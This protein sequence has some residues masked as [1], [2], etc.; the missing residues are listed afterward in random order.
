MNYDIIVFLILLW[1]G[2]VKEVYIFVPYPVLQ[3]RGTE[4]MCKAILISEVIINNCINREYSLNTSKLQKILYF[5]QKE[6]LRKYHTPIF[7]EDIIAWECGPAIK[8]IND[9]F[10]YGKLGFDDKVEQSIQLKDSHEEILELILHKYGSLSP[11][12]M[13]EISKKEFSWQCVWDDGNGNGK[14]IPLDLVM[15]LSER[16]IISTE[17]NNNA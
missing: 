13:A 15:P 3:K 8:E 17:E 11:L 12:E 9:Y 2:Y 16:N 6:H 14:M 4:K 10:T 5:M 1:S 7:D